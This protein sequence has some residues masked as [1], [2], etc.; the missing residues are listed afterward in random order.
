MNTMDVVDGCQATSILH[1]LH[2]VASDNILN[3]G[4]TKSSTSDRAV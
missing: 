3:M 2:S 1:V 4:V